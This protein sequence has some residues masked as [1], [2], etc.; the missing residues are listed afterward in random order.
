MKEESEAKRLAMDSRHHFIISIIADK[1]EMNSS[2]VEEH[3]LEG[4][5][6]TTKLKVAIDMIFH[7]QMQAMDDFFA[8]SGA[9]HLLIY[10]EHNKDVD[11]GKNC[12]I[13]RQT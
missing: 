12:E 5:Q 9:K 8:P 6:V 4:H 11:T 3:L 10:Y 13:F 1:L 7:N 2:E